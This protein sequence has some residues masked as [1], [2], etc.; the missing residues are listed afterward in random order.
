[1]A[2]SVHKSQRVCSLVCFDMW[3]CLPT[4][5]KPPSPGLSGESSVC[6][7][8]KYSLM[9]YSSVTPKHPVAVRFDKM[10]RI[11][12]ISTCTFLMGFVIFLQIFFLLSCFGSALIRKQFVFCHSAF[13]RRLFSHQWLW[14]IFNVI[15]GC[16]FNSFHGSATYIVPAH[17]HNI[18][19]FV[20]TV[21]PCRYWLVQEGVV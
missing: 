15:I 14:K 21:Y 9:Q 13:H 2:F 16:C 17:L 12:L 7:I 8:L 18:D 19:V 3:Y 4:T 20:F 5:G 10:T 1:M 11:S 6:W